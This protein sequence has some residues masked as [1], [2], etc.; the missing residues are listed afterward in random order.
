MLDTLDPIPLVLDESVRG[1]VR[2]GVVQAAPVRV[3]PAEEPLLAEIRS[4]VGE[5]TAR[6]RGQKPSDIPGLRHARDLYRAFGVDPTR[7]RPSSEA[8]LRRILQTKPFPCVNNAVDVCN[9]ASVRML[10]PLGLYDPAAL[11]GGVVLRRGRPGES[12]P[13][14]RKDEVHLEGRLTLVDELGPFGNPTSDSARASVRA[15]ARSLWV[16][17]FAPVAYPA[18]GLTDNVRLLAGLMAT[19]V[20]HPETPVATRY[21]TTA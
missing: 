1:Q 21:A 8:L 11:R 4:T 9:L 15:D 18:D 17:V 12:Y 14:I 10:L 7:T 3:A 6:Y 5:L 20:G 16:V 2:I 19:H 13:G